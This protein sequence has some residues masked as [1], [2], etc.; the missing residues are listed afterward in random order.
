[1]IITKWHDITT[2]E[3]VFMIKFMADYVMTVMDVHGGH[4][5]Y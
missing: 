2:E 3:I 1:M 5:W 4:T